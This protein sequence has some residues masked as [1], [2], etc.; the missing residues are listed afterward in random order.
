MRI[1]A[2]SDIHGNLPA[3]EAV[4]ADIAAQGAD[5]ILNLGD[6]AS[7]PLWPRETLERL[8]PLGL[9]TIAGNHERQVLTDP[10]GASDA[11]A[12]ARMTDEQQ[13]WFAALPPTRWLDGDAR[14]VFLCH[15]SPASDLVMWMET[16]DPGAPTLRA[17]T[18]AEI[19]AR[20]G[21]VDLAAA[22]LVLC[23]HTHVPR[24]VAL[25]AQRIVVNPGSVGLQAYDMD[26]PHPHVVENGT[27][28]A[29]YAIVERASPA[30]AWNVTLR[31]VAYDWHAAAA[32]AAAGNRPEWAS[33]L[34]RGW[35][36]A[37]E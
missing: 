30:S 3:L 20:A 27:P 11:F 21:G 13:A 4:L 22:T 18:H 24:V 16:I 34:A 33:G 32:R 31:A 35:L 1:A 10:R 26:E 14:D 6:I 29:R 17:A 8:M 5:V 36:R 23:G 28:H 9:P 15:G 37:T 25:D 19:A 2:I 7:G 12:A